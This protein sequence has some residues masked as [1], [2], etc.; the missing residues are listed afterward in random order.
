M[1]ARPRARSR[2]QQNYHGWIVHVA[3]F[4]PY[5]QRAG[6][7]WYTEATKHAYSFPGIEIHHASPDAWEAQADLSPCPQSPAFSTYWYYGAGTSRASPN[8]G[9][10]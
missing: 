5:Y 6:G 9:W 10:C 1:E 2:F 7:Q 8:D 3:V 4:S